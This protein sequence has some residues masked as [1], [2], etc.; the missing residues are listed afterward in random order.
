[1]PLFSSREE[2]PRYSVRVL[3][4]SEPIAERPVADWTAVR[5]TVGEAVETIIKGLEDDNQRE[6]AYAMDL[7]PLNRALT[8]PQTQQVVDTSG[9]WQTPLPIL[10]ASVTVT[11]LMPGSRPQGG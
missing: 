10:R 4:N 7:P 5:E 2:S 9:A 8:N 1:M 3:H 6:D 11:A